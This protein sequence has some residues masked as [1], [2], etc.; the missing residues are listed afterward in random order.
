MRKAFKF[1]ADRMRCDRTHN[2]DVDSCMKLY[3]SKTHTGAAFS[4]PFKYGNPPNRK[5]S[6]EKTMN[7]N[8]LK[9]VFAAPSFIDDYRD[10][11]SKRYIIQRSSKP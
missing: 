2:R 5:N 8:F 11:L 9:R 10:F 3:F 1:I 4:I 7:G 6:L